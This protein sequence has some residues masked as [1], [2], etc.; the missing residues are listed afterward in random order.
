[1]LKS[2]KERQF[3]VFEFEDGK[4][5]KYNLATGESIG[6][7]GRVVKNICSQLSGYS[8]LQVIQS[9]GDEKYRDF[10]LYVDKQV[11]KSTSTKYYWRRNRRVDKITNVG[12]FLSRL[13]DY[14]KYEQYF[15]S[16]LTNIDFP[17]NYKYTEI[18]KGL[19]KL[20]KENNYKLNNN[21]V[22]IYK[23]NPNLINTLMDID[24]YSID[25]N[26]IWNLLT[27]KDYTP[28]VTR[29]KLL[30]LITRYN[31]NPT[32]LIKYIDNLM[33]YEALDG[34][35]T[36]ITEL[37]DY[38]RMVSV[39]SDRYDKYPKNFLTTHKIATRNYQRL[40][41]QFNEDLFA[42]RIN[43]DLEYKYKDYVIIYPKTTQEIKDEAINLNHC[44]ASYIDR[45]IDGVCDILFLRKK[46]EPNKSLI[47]LEVRYN[48]VVQA[49]GKFNRDTSKEE[50]EIIEKY[51][52]KLEEKIC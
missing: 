26:S 16:G 22:E 24:F 20:C 43:E 1:M 5:V 47:T 19:I 6:K 13:N 36:I 41:K 10:L 49:R 37:H 21:I 52:K 45:V 28:R 51:N 11:N 2:Y 38:I 39:I 50:Q 42:R 44:V 14:S 35:I 33:T 17:M 29:E 40:R 9:F 25:K 4:T 3:L 18:P 7:S 34:L 27:S 30:D 32:S 12:T 23:T 31:Y 8:L 15:S 48:N 46:K